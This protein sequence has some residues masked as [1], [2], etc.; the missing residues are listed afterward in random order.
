[1]TAP[2]APN[3]EFATTLDISVASPLEVGDIGAGERRM[4]PIL[5]GTAKGPLLNGRILPGGSDIQI[6]R[7]DG[8]TD[9][10]ARYTIE[11][12]DGALVFIENR[13]VRGGP[14]ELL[15]KLRRGEPVDPKKIYFRTSPRFEAASLVHQLLAQSLFIAVGARHPDR[16]VLDVWRIA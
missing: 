6:V 15:A 13:G 12:D 1:L 8:T 4:I 7:R 10:V 11:A 3:F 16:V 5:G 9:L 2:E 14:P